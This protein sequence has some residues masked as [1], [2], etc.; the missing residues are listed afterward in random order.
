MPTV[1]WKVRETSHLP[2]DAALWMGSLSWS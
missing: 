1:T 2:N